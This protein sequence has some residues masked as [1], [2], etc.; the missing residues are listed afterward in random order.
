MPNDSKSPNGVP[1]EVLEAA[2][3]M[4]T[5]MAEQARQEEIQEALRR[6]EARREEVRQAQQKPARKSAVQAMRIWVAKVRNAGMSLESV[7]RGEFV[8]YSKARIVMFPTVLPKSQ[9]RI[10]IWMSDYIKKG[11]LR[12]Q[13]GQDGGFHG[14]HS[15]GPSDLEFLHDFFAGDQAWSDLKILFDEKASGRVQRR[16]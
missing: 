3:R 1:A 16:V 10:G 2:E 8:A 14:M 6:D 9:L 4:K 12:L 15:L 11:E 13:I 5:A 7:A